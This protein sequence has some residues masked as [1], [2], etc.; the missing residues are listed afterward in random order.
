VYVDSRI[1]LVMQW[2]RE[3]NLLFIDKYREKPMLW[4]PCPT[5]GAHTSTVDPSVQNEHSMRLTSCGVM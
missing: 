1:V 2:D 4:D 5:C 3:K